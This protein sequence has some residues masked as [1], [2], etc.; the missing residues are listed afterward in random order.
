MR[1]QPLKEVDGVRSPCETHEATHLRIQFPR[2]T[3]EID[4]WPIT[5]PVRLS[6]SRKG[7]P[8]WSWNGDCEKPTLRPSVLS[9]CGDFICHSWVTDGQANFLSDCSHEFKN[10]TIDLLELP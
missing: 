3:G 9:T 6:G 1:A 7:N 5:L 8:Q 4:G 10:Q 2:G